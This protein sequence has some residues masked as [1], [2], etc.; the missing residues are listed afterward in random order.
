LYNLK[1][2]YSIRINNHPYHPYHPYRFLDYTPMIPKRYNQKVMPINELGEPY[3][4]IEKVNVGS[5]IGMLSH[6]AKH[7]TNIEI[8]EDLLHDNILKA[9]N[10]VVLS[11][12]ILVNRDTPHD[13]IIHEF[14]S[15]R[16]F[17]TFVYPKLKEA[18]DEL[19]MT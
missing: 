11:P 10:H 6:Y 14:G 17:S 9:I 4:H 1:Y 19:L 7:S 16:G 3:Y 18:L 5:V 13:F 2:N 8:S 12:E 15:L